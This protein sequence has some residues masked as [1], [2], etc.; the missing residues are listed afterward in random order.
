M[1]LLF[2]FTRSIHDFIVTLNIPNDIDSLS[3]QQLHHKSIQSAQAIFT[4]AE[5]IKDRFTTGYLASMSDFTAA[6]L[7]KD[8]TVAFVEPDNAVNITES[9]FFVEKPNAMVKTQN[10]APWGIAR[11]SSGM[12]F[13]DNG[14][15]E[16]PSV[17]GSNVDVYILD[18]GIDMSHKGLNAVWG[19]NLVEGSPDT[20]EHGH[21]THVAG[22]IGGTGTGLAKKSKLIAVKILDKSGAGKISRVILGI[23]YV[24]RMHAKKEDE[25]YETRN[26]EN[27]EYRIVSENVKEAVIQSK[28]VQEILSEVIKENE[29][30]DQ[31]S[32]TSKYEMESSENSLKPFNNEPDFYNTSDNNSDYANV[33]VNQ[34]MEG[35]SAVFNDENIVTPARNNKNNQFLDKLANFLKLDHARPRTVV[36]MSVGGLKSRALEFAVDYA[37][38]TGIHFSVA[39]GNDHEDACMY[40]PGSSKSAITVGASTKKD[41]VAFFSNIGHCVDIFAPGTEIFSTWPGNEY[42][43]ASGTSMAAP[44][45]TG[46]MALYL[47]LK[48]YDPTE[49]KTKI[50]KDGLEVVIN[51]DDEDMLDF[52]PLKYLFKREKY[53]LVSS[54][55]LNDAVKSEIVKK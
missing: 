10:H 32:E 21:G 20:D 35:D 2:S 44:H 36:N 38:R 27:V 39:A 28:E 42:R 4:S 30:E 41:V 43:M 26:D 40:S 31:S 24:I 16:Y 52:W 51:D 34:M 47:S 23:D 29:Q 6:R 49:L 8:P 7:A 33:D 46:V 1:L 50:I 5:R 15:Y 48:Y 14:I 13:R 11:V 54:K 55:K 12:K 53:L 25:L 9:G 37:A 22:T 45:V 19:I 18:T 3:L 17:A